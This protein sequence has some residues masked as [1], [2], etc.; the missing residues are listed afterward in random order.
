MLSTIK[1]IETVYPWPNGPRYRSRLEARWAVFFDT[2]GIKYEYEKEGYTL[3]SGRYLPDFWLPQVSMW[4]EVKPI[5]FEYDEYVKCLELYLATGYP[6]MKL[7]GTP[8]FI[9]YDVIE[10]TGSD[11]SIAEIPYTIGTDYLREHRFFCMGYPSGSDDFD[12][13]YHMAVRAARQARFEH[14][15]HGR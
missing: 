15:E 4:A 12:P 10:A 2:L 8:D 13:I 6:V 14:G 3:K 11:N 5:E 9:E 1:A 7:V